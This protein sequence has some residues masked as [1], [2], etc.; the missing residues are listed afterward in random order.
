MR[1]PYFAKPLHCEIR[2][3]TRSGESAKFDVK[4]EPTPEG[5][6]QKEVLRCLRIYAKKQRLIEMYKQMKASKVTS[7]PA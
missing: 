2:R 1:N 4:P 6:F 3:T 7:I 5:I